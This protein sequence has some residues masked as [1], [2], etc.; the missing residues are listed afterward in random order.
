[1]E[2]E[3]EGKKNKR[4]GD[5]LLKNV[6]QNQKE[7]GER[8]KFQD[9]TIDTENIWYILD[10]ISFSPQEEG[11]VDGLLYLHQVTGRPFIILMIPPS[12]ESPN[13]EYQICFLQKIQSN[14]GELDGYC[15]QIVSGPNLIEEM[16]LIIDQLDNYYCSTIGV[17]DENLIQEGID[18]MILFLR[19]E[20]QSPPQA[21][22]RKIMKG[23]RSLVVDSDKM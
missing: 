1:M 23:K 11:R 19:G 22:A 5:D 16:N 9:F 7:Y 18:D 13:G 3:V 20:P 8:F 17:I 10:V 14:H 12:E 4:L 2:E 6:S 15:F 21:Q